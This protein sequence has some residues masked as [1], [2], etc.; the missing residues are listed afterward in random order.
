MTTPAEAAQV[1]AKCACYDPVFSRPDAALA[2]GWAE[3]F[4]RYQLELPDLLAA[5]TS[6]YS[7]SADRAMPVHLIRIAREIRRVRAEREKAAT[8]HH[9][10]QALPPGTAASETRRAEVMR[11]VRQIA[12]RKAVPAAYSQE[13]H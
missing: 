5:V 7:E 9:A 3:A 6:H 8:E 12:N 4:D 11:M 13:N 10:A 2:V 1:L